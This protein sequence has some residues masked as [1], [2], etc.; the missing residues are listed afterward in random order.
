MRR[1]RSD[2][3]DASSAPSLVEV[4]GHLGGTWLRSH[5]IRFLAGAVLVSEI[6]QGSQQ[7]NRGR[8]RSDQE[9]LAL[10]LDDGNE[11]AVAERGSFG[12]AESLLGA[13]AVD[14]G[15]P[16]SLKGTPQNGERL[17]ESTGECEGRCGPVSSRP[18]VEE[19][20]GEIGVEKVGWKGWWGSGFGPR[21]YR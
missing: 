9:A 6:G 19:M 12:D 16:E 14:D 18:G 21:E 15:A 13:G 20:G 5:A 1:G 17:R 4:G 7:G 10:E 3:R 2:G 8:T 11:A